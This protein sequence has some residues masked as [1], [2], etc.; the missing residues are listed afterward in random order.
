MPDTP[1]CIVLVVTMTPQQ[2]SRVFHLAP[3]WIQLKLWDQQC[4]LLHFFD[5]A[6]LR[7]SAFA[8]G[9]SVLKS[10][11]NVVYVIQLS[12]FLEVTQK[13]SR[14]SSPLR[15]RV[16]HLSRGTRVRALSMFRRPSEHR[17]DHQKLQAEGVLVDVPEIAVL[18][19]TPPGSKIVFAKPNKLISAVVVVE[20]FRGNL[21][22]LINE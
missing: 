22:D 3:H 20:L 7:L 17:P 18:V 1:V 2:L 8:V 11:S 21:R 13:R 9:R 14:D 10:P 16:A 5:G 6:G 12:S 19:I 15:G 4:R